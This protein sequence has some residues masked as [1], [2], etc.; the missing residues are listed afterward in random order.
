MQHATVTLLT[1]AD[2]LAGEPYSAI[3]HEYV[4]GHVYAM[5][6]ASKAHNT[7]TLNIATRLHVHLRGSPC[8]AYVA[9]MRV[10]VETARAYYYPDVVVSCAGP[11]TAADAPSHYLTAPVL[12]AEILSEST[13][14][15]DR[16]E[17]MR[18][19]AQLDS[20]REY[21]LVDSRSARAELYRR[22]PEGGWE[23]WIAAPGETLR[24][25]SVGLD[26]AVDDLYEDV[27]F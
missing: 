23:Q 14:T 10:R 1:E 22:G 8:R 12:I 26:L 13:E 20:L 21:L 7:I 15:I 9:E 3:R 11:D 2:Y 24:L 16:R 6:G 5:A 19:Y 25:D 27:T 4:D 17:K 18:A